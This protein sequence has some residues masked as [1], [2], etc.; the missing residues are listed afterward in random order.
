MWNLLGLWLA[1][2]AVMP[3]E[4]ASWIEENQSPRSH[5]CFAFTSIMFVF[6]VSLWGIAALK[7]WQLDS[8][9]SSWRTPSR[10]LSQNS[11]HLIHNTYK[12]LQNM[13][14]LLCNHLIINEQEHSATIRATEW[15]FYFVFILLTRPGSQG[16][17][18][19]TWSMLS[20]TPRGPTGGQNQASK[21]LSS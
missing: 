21:L 4:K 5:L 7:P 3:S 11:K 6:T 2:T 16:S 9:V 17:T 14:L 19:E 8:Q 18:S 20:W 1:L 10:R 13:I 15:T 12:Y